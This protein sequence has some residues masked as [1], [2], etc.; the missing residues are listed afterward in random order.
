[1]ADGE[2]ILMTDHGSTEGSRNV[3][4]T[5]V[6]RLTGR[7]PV[8]LDARHFMSGGDG[9]IETDG[10]GLRLTADRRSVTAD[11]VLV[12]EIPPHRRRDFEACQRRLHAHGARSLGTGADAWRAATEKD[13]TVDRLTRDGVPHM[14][15]LTLRRPTPQEAADAFDRL[16]GDV[17]ARPTVGMGGNDVFHLTTHR[18][19]ADAAAHYAAQGADWLIARDAANFTPDGRRHQYRA[20]VLGERVVR[21]VEHIQPDPDAPCNESQGAASTLLA[22]EDL[23]AGLAELAVS[24]TKCLGL[25]FAG[26][27]LAAENGGVVFEVNVHPMFGTVRGLETVA[28]PYVAAHLEL[29]RRPTPA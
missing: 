16:G 29:N 21:A 28:L 14:P 24:A 15:T 5:A 2:L 13:L 3:L 8:L 19:L 7:A 11:T 10:T 18:Q 6:R 27:D 22:V 17:W 26:V 25:P 4:A 23:P 9:R 20:V 12:Y 1:M